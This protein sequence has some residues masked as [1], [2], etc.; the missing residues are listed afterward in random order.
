MS[1]PDADKTRERKDLEHVTRDAKPE[2]QQK[3]REAL[4]K[5]HENE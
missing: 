2:T 3:A 1:K 5:L 4:D